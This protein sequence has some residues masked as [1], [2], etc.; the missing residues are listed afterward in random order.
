MVSEPTIASQ[1]SP[2]LPA[3]AGVVL[4]EVLPEL[5][6]F[7]GDVPNVHDPDGEGEEQDGPDHL[8]LE[9]ESQME[10]DE[11]QVHRV[12]CEAVWTCGDECRG[13][14]VGANRGPDA[15]ERGEC[16]SGQ[17]RREDQKEPGKVDKQAW[18]RP[19]QGDPVVQHHA[20]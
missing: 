12:A 14:V 16:R 6:F 5:L 20:Q 8:K 11:G 15:E 10:E 2:D 17:Q 7:L 13:R 3:I 4:G 19:P 1:P 9:G 18:E